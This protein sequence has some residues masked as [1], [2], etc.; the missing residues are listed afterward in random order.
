MWRV[1]QLRSVVQRVM[2]DNVHQDK[3]VGSTYMY[4]GC[5]RLNLSMCCRSVRLGRTINRIVGGV[6]EIDD[7]AQSVATLMGG[8]TLHVQGSSRVMP[9]LLKTNCRVTWVSRPV[10][11]RPR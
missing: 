1:G 7:S 10:T 9:T 5:L 2:A 8:Q 4:Y 3:K 11:L 6:S